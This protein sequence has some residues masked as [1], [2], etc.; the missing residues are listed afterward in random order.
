MAYLSAGIS[1]GLAAIGGGIGIAIL[2]SKAFESIARQPEINNALRPLV[3]IGIA[4]IEAI[5]LY[6]LVIS[7][8]LVT[9]G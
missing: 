1:M 6:A 5:V 7:I 2:M 9:K 3:F 4:F 8:L